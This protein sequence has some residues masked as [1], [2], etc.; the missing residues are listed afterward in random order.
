MGPTIGVM[1][2]YPFQCF[3]KCVKQ[4]STSLTGSDEV[5]LAFLVS[6]TSIV[7]SAMLTSSAVCRN[8]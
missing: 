7:V 4:P 6:L 3:D 5:S 8:A 2:T 1:C